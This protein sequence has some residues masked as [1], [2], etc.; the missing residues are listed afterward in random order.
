MAG[1]AL[2]M[3][4]TDQRE[5]VRNV[6][7]LRRVSEDEKPARGDPYGQVALSLTK[8]DSEIVRPARSDA[9]KFAILL[10][11]PKHITP[12]F[13]AG[14]RRDNAICR[15]QRRINPHGN[16]KRYLIGA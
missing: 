11:L 3:N 5:K 12:K 2:M 6:G 13:S 14:Q 1:K 10:G 15:S 7:G 8:V 4:N 16:T 9:S